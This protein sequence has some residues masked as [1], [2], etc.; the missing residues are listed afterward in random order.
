MNAV[1]RFAQAS[2][3]FQAGV[4]ANLSDFGMGDRFNAGA[5]PKLIRMG[6][7]ASVSKADKT[8][9]WMEAVSYAIEPTS[10]VSGQPKKLA[11]WVTLSMAR[12]I[13]ERA[14]SDDTVARACG[15]CFPRQS[16]RLNGGMREASSDDDDF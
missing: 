2:D 12:K 7:S 4:I 16:A 15:I 11:D 10:L 5:A 1:P 13:I 14:M 9:E 6:A 8:H 3:N